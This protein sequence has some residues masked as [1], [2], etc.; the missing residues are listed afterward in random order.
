MAYH[1]WQG[2]RA[3]LMMPDLLNLGSKKLRL[4]RKP[5][6]LAKLA[7]F[8]VHMTVTHLEKS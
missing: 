2:N 4:S 1:R 6:L 8:C 5:A 7:G 3:G